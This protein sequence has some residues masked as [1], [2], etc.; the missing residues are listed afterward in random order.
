VSDPKRIFETG[1][2]DAR[3]LLEAHPRSMTPPDG[4]EDEVWNALQAKLPPPDPGGGSGNA[5]TAPVSK[6]IGAVALG[7]VA[8]AFAVFALRPAEPNA[9]SPLP[10]VPE[11]VVIATARS[12]PAPT[13][14]V[15]VKEA[16]EPTPAAKAPVAPSST[17]RTGMH[18]STSV[19]A[20]SSA[21]A[22]QKPADPEEEAAAVREARAVLRQGDA[23][24]AL[25][26]L[27]TYERAHRGGILGQERD[28][29]RIEAMRATGDPRVRAKMDAFLKAYPDSPYRERISPK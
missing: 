12:A 18:S 20:F 24:G 17:S 27:D 16:E 19:A 6:L 11:A 28:F 1:S 7:G 10:D 2:S 26:R 29:L 21:S 23:A 13:L 5:P 25:V 14:D 8:I 22:S 9:I 15:T 4:A 3:L